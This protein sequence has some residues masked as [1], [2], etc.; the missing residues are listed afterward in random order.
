MTLPAHGAALSFAIAATELAEEH[1]NRRA[2]QDHLNVGQRRGRA[3]LSWQVH[4][5]HDQGRQGG[6][7]SVLSDET[8]DMRTLEVGALGK[9]PTRPYE[10]EFRVGLIAPTTRPGTYD[11]FVSVGRRDGTPVI[12]LPLPDDDGQRR[13]WLGTITLAKRKVPK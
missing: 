11:I 13:D 1:C 4:G 2:V 8:L 5:D 9:A 6:L 12:A 10:S 7:V 3:M